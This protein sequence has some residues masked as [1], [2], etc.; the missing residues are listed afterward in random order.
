MV[1]IL[2]A[3]TGGVQRVT[4]LILELVFER[5]SILELG[6][7]GLSPG[8]DRRNG[9]PERHGSGGVHVVLAVLEGLV[10]T[11]Q[12]LQNLRQ[13]ALDLDDTKKMR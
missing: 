4:N 6:L 10:E 2:W 11:V 13:G 1:L 3:K 12:P 5:L 7:V 8:H 9:V